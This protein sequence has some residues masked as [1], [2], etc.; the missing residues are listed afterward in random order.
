MIYWQAYVH[1]LFFSSFTYLFL[2]LLLYYLKKLFCPSLNSKCLRLP[3]MCRLIA[4]VEL[5]A[6]GTLFYS[7]CCEKK[8]TKCYTN[9]IQPHVFNPMKC[10]VTQLCL[11]LRTKEQPKG[12][13]LENNSR[14]CRLQLRKHTLKRPSKQ[15]F[16]IYTGNFCFDSKT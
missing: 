6:R 15:Y 8:R 5:A 14:S 3:W 13:S 2:F 1:L 16:P 9:T 7:L 4:I 12:T 10:I 11:E